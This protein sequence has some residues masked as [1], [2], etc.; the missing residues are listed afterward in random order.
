MQ[1]LKLATSAIALIIFLVLPGIS[2]KGGYYTQRFKDSLN[3]GSFQDRL[4][5]TIFI[6]ILFQICI[7]FINNYFFAKQIDFETYTVFLT[8]DIIKSEN[9]VSLDHDTLIFAIK[10][11]VFC[12]VFPF[13]IGFILN[14]LICL[15]NLD[16][17]IS[18]LR[19]NDL[20]H[21][22]FRGNIPNDNSN[23]K[24]NKGFKT[25]ST[26]VD[27]LVEVPN[28]TR[29]YSGYYVTHT[30][31]KNSNDLDSIILTDVQRYSNTQ[32]KFVVVPGHYFKIKG[33]KLVNIN[34][35]HTINELTKKS[36]STDPSTYI[37]IFFLLLISASLIIPFF[38]NT[39]V[40]IL[41]ANII[42]GLFFSLFF[43]TLLNSI[44]S[45]DKSERIE[46][47]SMIIL[48]IIISLIIYFINK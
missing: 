45:K 47:I 39:G 40:V 30:L 35:R 24:K 44:F 33:D 9:K 5:S 32:K 19:S 6:S 15:F 43:T 8:E 16:L 36:K 17:H 10:Y 11:L 46:I 18:Y 2:F 31:K 38:L 28:D 29:L 25:G 1:D 13:F 4:F 23:I 20:W 42:L 14:K 34:T 26:L 7:I 12:S 3:S 22:Y 21:Y 41:I 48:T 27:V 37:V